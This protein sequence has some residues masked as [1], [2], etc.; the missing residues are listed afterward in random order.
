[1]K[2]TRSFGIRLIAQ[3]GMV[4]LSTTAW[5]QAFLVD[6]KTV[7]D[8]GSGVNDSPLATKLFLEGGTPAPLGTPIWF[9]ADLQRDG[10]RS[11]TLGR[12]TLLPSEFLGAD[13]HV[14]LRDMV[15]GDQ[16]GA[17]AGRFRRVGASVQIPAGA[18]PE[19]VL[20]A[21]IYV[22]LWD[23]ASVT[24]APVA[25]A[26]FGLL[27]LGV[28]SRPDLG[29]PFWAIQEDL[30]ATS[31]AVV[32]EPAVTLGAG[33]MLAGWIAGRLMRRNPRGDR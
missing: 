16:P 20:A 24:D 23:T 8:V 30:S 6:I 26:Q 2:S 21:N 29:N 14:L 22:V 17:Q 15:D 33:L 5:A 32:P 28:R 11:E 4:A 25:G 19:A 31:Y 27:N 1:M 13:D 3:L 18:A 10:L 12:T 9:V 7:G